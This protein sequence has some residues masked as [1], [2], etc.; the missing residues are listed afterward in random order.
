MGDEALFFPAQDAG[1]LAERI[2]QL[3][4]SD[5]LRRSLA[6]SGHRHVARYSWDASAEALRKL[7]HEV[8]RGGRP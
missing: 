7:L 2:L 4:G 1:V 5:T 6:E 8:V 3:L